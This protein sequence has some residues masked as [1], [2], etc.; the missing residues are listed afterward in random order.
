MVA[1]ATAAASSELQLQPLSQVPPSAP[2][3]SPPKSATKEREEREL[4]EFLVAEG[5]PM[6]VI[7]HLTAKKVVSLK[8][9]FAIHLIFG[10]DH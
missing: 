9:F 10:P 8:I 6:E 1:N 5:I 7:E 2:A 4:K 3:A